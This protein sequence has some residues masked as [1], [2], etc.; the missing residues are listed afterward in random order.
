MSTIFSKIIARE[1]PADIIHEDEHCLAF[2]DIQ[3]VAP[4]HVLVIPRKPIVSLG[5]AD[6]SDNALLGHCLTIC[7]KVAR[8]AGQDRA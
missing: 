4:F 2:R 7:T 5:T 3:P 1:L 6:E 8:D